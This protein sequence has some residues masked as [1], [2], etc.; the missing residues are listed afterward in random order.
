MEFTDKYARIDGSDDDDAMSTGGNKVNYSD[1]EFIDDERNYQDQRPSD[2]HLRNVTRDLQE[3]SL[4]QSMSADL[5]ECTDPGNFVSN[6][7]EE[8]ELEFDE[9]DG[10]RNRIKKFEQD[11]KIHE[12]DSS[13]SFYFAILYATYYALQDKKEDFDFCQDRDKP[14]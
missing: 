7:V 1:V 12:K 4:D 2:Y 9:F 13:D 3:A 14:I 5:S 10:F 8:I 6:H 11:L